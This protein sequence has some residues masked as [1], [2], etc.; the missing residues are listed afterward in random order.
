MDPLPLLTATSGHI[1]IWWDKLAPEVTLGACGLWAYSEIEFSSKAPKGYKKEN[2][3]FVTA[4][5]LAQI[6]LKKYGCTDDGLGIKTADGQPFKISRNEMY[7]MNH[8]YEENEKYANE[9]WAK[10]KKRQANRV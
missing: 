10:L 1:M 3:C 2:Y 7:N 9:L 6:Y 8:Q 4:D 5:T